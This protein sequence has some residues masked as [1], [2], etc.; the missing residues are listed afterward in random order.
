MDNQDFEFDFGFKIYK[1]FEY[2]SV[3]EG[4]VEK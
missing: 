1:N 3:S 4:E 2:F